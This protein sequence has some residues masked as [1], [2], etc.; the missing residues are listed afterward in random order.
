MA[1]AN[2]LALLAEAPSWLAA[3]ARPAASTGLV[4]IR[5]LRQIAGRIPLVGEL[6]DRPVA[7]R[8]RLAVLDQPGQR[9]KARDHPHRVGRAQRLVLNMRGWHR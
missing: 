8:T 4:D 3:V 9:I 1:Q 6:L 2:L 7:A 5:P